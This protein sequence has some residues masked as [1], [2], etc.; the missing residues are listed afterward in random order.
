M[1]HTFGREGGQGGGEPWNRLRIEARPVLAVRISV[2]TAGV[3]EFGLEA[4]L[5]LADRSPFLSHTYL[6]A[7]QQQ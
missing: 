7:Y 4:L 1:S 6:R 5:L 3:G 2:K